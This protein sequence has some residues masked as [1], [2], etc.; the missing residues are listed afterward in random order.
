VEP[1][2]RKGQDAIESHFPEPGDGHAKRLAVGFPHPV[3][4][5]HACPVPYR[6]ILVPSLEDP[7]PYD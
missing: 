5:V 1:V 2:V 6:R 4:M 3:P 7:R